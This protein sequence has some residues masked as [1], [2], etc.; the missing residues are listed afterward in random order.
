MENEQEDEYLT[1]ELVVD[2]SFCSPLTITATNKVITYCGNL[3]INDCF[4]EYDEVNEE[5][6]IS[7]LDFKVL[8]DEIKMC[9]IPI[10]PEEFTM[11]LD[12]TTYTI[13]II[14]GDNCAEFSWWET[15]PL[16]WEILGDLAEN[17]IKFCKKKS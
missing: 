10:M 16:E 7:P 11:G 17:L 12:G 9:K 3:E 6:S 2:P 13:R 14:N 1:I 8:I 4:I 15:C 5:I